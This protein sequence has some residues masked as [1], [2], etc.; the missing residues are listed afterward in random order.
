MNSSNKKS[1]ASN[2]LEEYCLEPTTLY[3]SNRNL[4]KNMNRVT[5]D[6]AFFT[7]ITVFWSTG[8]KKQ[9]FHAIFNGVGDFF[10]T[11]STLFV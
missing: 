5:L 2:P 3:G 10:F 1:I 8:Y 11:V 6:F 9:N 7:W 4:L